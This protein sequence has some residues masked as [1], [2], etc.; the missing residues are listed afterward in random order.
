MTWITLKRLLLLFWAVW[1]SGVVVFN[2]TDALKA[3]GVLPAT[4]VW[5]SGNFGAIQDVLAPFDLPAAL[6]GFFLAGVIAWEAL[7]AALYWRCGLSFAGFRQPDSRRRLVVTFATS[8]GLWAGFQIA[9]EVFPSE[10][11]YQL[12][13]THR[14]VFIETL[15]TLLAIALLPDE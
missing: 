6:A 9:C 4:F 1:L 10:L 5:A 11:A 8:L 7:C 15:A 3:F 14:V 13:A 2:T 12:G